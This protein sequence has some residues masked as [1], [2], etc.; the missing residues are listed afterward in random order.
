L[1]KLKLRLVP[2]RGCSKT[3][4][5]IALILSKFMLTISELLLGLV[6]FTFLSKSIFHLNPLG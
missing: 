1:T 3:C 4:C 2:A 6:F 5:V